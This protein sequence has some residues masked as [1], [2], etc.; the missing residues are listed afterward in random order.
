MRAEP[1]LAP[2]GRPRNDSDLPFKLQTGAA[3]ATEAH[4]MCGFFTCDVRPFNPLLEALP[5]FMRIGRGTSAADSDEAAR[6]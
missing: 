5:R 3:G 2:Y 4:L 1:D 6:V